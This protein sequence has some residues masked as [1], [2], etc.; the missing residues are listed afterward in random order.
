[1]RPSTAGDSAN[2]VVPFDRIGGGD[3]LQK[4]SNQPWGIERILETRFPHQNRSVGGGENDI[5]CA[6]ATLEAQA[7]GSS[8]LT[9]AGANSES[10]V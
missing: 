10:L 4:V 9:V 6:G 7:D 1:M 5:E 2:E 3:Q 8:S